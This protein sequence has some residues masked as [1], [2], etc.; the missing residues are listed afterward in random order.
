MILAREQL[1][2]MSKE[3]LSGRWNGKALQ[4]L[5]MFLLLCA[6][7]GIIGGI[8]SISGNIHM[9]SI[10]HGFNWSVT[11]DNAAPAGFLFTNIWSFIISAFSYL[12]MFGFIEGCMKTRIGEEAGTGVIFSKFS[13]YKRVLAFTV[14]YFCVSLVLQLASWLTGHMIFIGALLSLAVTFFSVWLYM[15]ISMAKY[16]LAENPYTE[17]MTAFL[18]S[19]NLMRGHSFRLFVLY[20]SFIGWAIAGAFTLG[21]GYLWLFPYAM[22]TE[23]NFYYDLK[24]AAAGAAGDNFNNTEEDR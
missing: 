22:M 24:H 20:L 15:R 13:M 19:Y 14:V 18:Q 16:I 21:I 3:Q 12:L 5:V 8:F 1:K 17:V 23:L 6:A 11:A 7:G 10:E 9:F 4:A 2:Q